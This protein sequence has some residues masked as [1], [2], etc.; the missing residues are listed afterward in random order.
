[1]IKTCKTSLLF[2]NTPHNTIS[3][4]FPKQTFKHW[5]IFS[6]DK[7]LCKTFKQ[8][9]LQRLPKQRPLFK[10]FSKPHTKHHFKQLKSKSK[11]SKQVTKSPWITMDENGACT[12]PFHNLPPEPKK[13]S[14][15]SFLCFLT[16]PLDKIKSRWRL[17]IN[18][19]IC[20]HKRKTSSQFS[21]RITLWML[22]KCI[23]V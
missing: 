21:H 19:N 2:S 15:R 7:H 1:M 14:Q 9:L 13:T 3:K 17:L 4:H 8:E 20:E 12:F 10:T 6:K 11:W 22:L 18:R 23:F 5:N 16:F